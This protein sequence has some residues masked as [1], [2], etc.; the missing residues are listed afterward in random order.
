MEE[1]IL[2]KLG[3]SLTPDWYTFVN[4]VLK[5]R[6]AVREEP[7]GGDLPERDI[8]DSDSEGELQYQCRF[9]DSSEI[10]NKL[11]G[12]IPFEEDEEEAEEDGEEE[13]EEIM[14]AHHSSS[15]DDEDE[16]EEDRE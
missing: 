5:P 6:V 12:F 10:L 13:E 9:T 2:S 14:I 15:D 1:L 16:D 4:S 8:Y 3:D 7:Y 11:L